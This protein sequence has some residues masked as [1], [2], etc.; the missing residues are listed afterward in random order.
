ML[1]KENTPRRKPHAHGPVMEEHRFASEIEELTR[2]LQGF[3]LAELAE[4]PILKA[5]AR[6]EPGRIY[7]DLEAEDA[8]PFTATG[9]LVAS[10]DNFYVAKHFTPRQYWNR[11]LVLGRSAADRMGHWKRDH[12]RS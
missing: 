3:T 12:S 2:R 10:R 11:L 1:T 6:L 7:L 5:G 4:I 9:D 8:E